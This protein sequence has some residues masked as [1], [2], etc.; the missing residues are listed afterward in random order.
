MATYNM[1]SA[2]VIAYFTTPN[3]T[4]I[5]TYPQNYKMNKAR[6]QLTYAICIMS[7]SGRMEQTHAKAT[8]C[9][10]LGKRAKYIKTAAIYEVNIHN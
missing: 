6:S 2:T 8:T 9:D 7:Q 3:L 4:L 1:Q 5:I 10:S